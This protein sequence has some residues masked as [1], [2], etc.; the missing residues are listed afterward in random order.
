MKRKKQNEKSVAEGAIEHCVHHL[1]RHTS[2]AFGN[3]F[4]QID[5]EPSKPI[6]YINRFS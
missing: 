5:F 6:L 3:Q 2:Y 1:L 4:S